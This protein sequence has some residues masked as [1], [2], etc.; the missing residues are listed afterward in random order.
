M[1]R[2][3]AARS[4]P[5]ASSSRPQQQQ[6]QQP[7]VATTTPAAA[8]ASLCD[9]AEAEDRD[10]AWESGALRPRQA[11][12]RYREFMTV[13]EHNEV[14]QFPEVRGQTLPLTHL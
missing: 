12:R 10:G 14:L 6:L 9:D 4:G 3:A 5:A 7:A 11:L 8:A 13:F 2:D 1:Q